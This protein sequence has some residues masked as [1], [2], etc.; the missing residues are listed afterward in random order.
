MQA[1]AQDLTVHAAAS[2]R[3]ALDEVAT[4][5]A[6]ETGGHLTL[7][8]AGSSALARQIAA[9]APGDVFVS[10][11][12]AWMDVLE[13]GG[14]LVAGS[15]GDL[16]TNSLVVIAPAGDDAPLD[17]ATLPERIGTGRLALALTEA[18]PAGIYAR[19]AL[20]NLAL[21]DAVAPRVVEADNVRAALAL[22]ASGAA[23]LGIVYA[24]DAIAE[25]RVT[26]IS[27]VPTE[28]HDAIVYPAAALAQGDAEGSAALLALMRSEAAGEVFR[29]HG[30]GLIAD[31]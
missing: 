3:G 26:V 15:R 22:V 23:P 21:W 17:L 10:A 31:D 24:T 20:S 27:E 9:G 1:N 30:F 6:A 8:Y 16:L 14:H 13:E 18:V 29:R 2:L 25:P 7:V 4:L 28:A 12:A 11:N 19:Q 5:W